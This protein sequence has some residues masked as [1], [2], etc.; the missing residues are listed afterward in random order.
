MNEHDEQLANTHELALGP[1]V[2]PQKLLRP[3]LSGPMPDRIIVNS[4]LGFVALDFV[5]LM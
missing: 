5:G 2:I 3:I 1:A 4:G